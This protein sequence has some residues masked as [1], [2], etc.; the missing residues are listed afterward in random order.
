MMR[1][2]DTEATTTAPATTAA[3]RTIIL[4]RVSFRYS[5]PDEDG[6]HGTD[7]TDITLSVRA[8][9]TVLLCG[10]SGCGKQP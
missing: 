3:A 4:D 2:Y 8:G 6:P 5:R 7:L 9:E 1:A 10:E